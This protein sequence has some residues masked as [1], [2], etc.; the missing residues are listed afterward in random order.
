MNS[1]FWARA[2][3]VAMAVGQTAFVLLYGTAPWWRDFVGRALFAKSLALA[4]LVDAAVVALFL[5]VPAWFAVAVYWLVAA[6]I[7]WQ[8]GALVRQRLSRRRTTR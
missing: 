1:M 8:L 7:W 4:V 6:G 5:P 2:A 3:V